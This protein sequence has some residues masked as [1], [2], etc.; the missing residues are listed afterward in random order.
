[1]AMG[2]KREIERLVRYDT[3]ATREALRTLRATPSPTG[4]RRLA[5]ILGAQRTWLHRI[6]GG[7]PVE[8]WP[9]PD[10]PSCEEEIKE[11]SHRWLSVVETED[12][13]RTV[14]YANTKGQRFENTVAEILLQVLLHGA[15]H[16]GQIAADVRA[17]G[18]EPALTDLIHA[19]REKHV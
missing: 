19:I 3:W 5:H 18:G 10:L 16:R 11:L 8:V 9:E 2:W 17:A 12:P 14:L 6:A 13:D 1:M 7:P 4:A 15:Y